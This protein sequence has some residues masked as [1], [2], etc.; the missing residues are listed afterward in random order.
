MRQRQREDLWIWS[1]GESQDCAPHLLTHS[2]ETVRPVS[3]HYLRTQT[4]RGE[5]NRYNHTG[6]SDSYFE[7]WKESAENSG[8][9]KPFCKRSARHATHSCPNVFAEVRA[10]I[11]PFLGGA[12]ALWR[13]ARSP[14]A[15]L[16]PQ[17]GSVKIIATML[18]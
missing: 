8:A 2:A 12:P 11:G 4:A 10:Q 16:F 13:A 18:K 15:A 17:P 5:R 7:P 14:S 1:P 9:E 3:G 6:D